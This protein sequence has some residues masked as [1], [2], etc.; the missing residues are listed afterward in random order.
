M[1]LYLTDSADLTSVADAIR[2]KGGTAAPLAFPQGFV[3]AID[4]IPTGGGASVKEELLGYTPQGDVTYIP[5]ENIPIHGICGKRGMTSLTLDFAAG[6]GFASSNSSGYNL[7]ANHIPKITIRGSVWLPA[8]VFYDNSSAFVVVCRDG[9]T[10]Y[11]QNVFR[12]NSG[13]TTLDFTYTTGDGIGVNDFYGDSAFGT[14]IIR[15]SSVMPLSNISAFSNATKFRNGGSGGKLYVPQALV[16]EY[17]Q[18]TN[19]STILGYANNQILPIE[20]SIYETQYADGTPI[21]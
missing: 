11:R 8:Y 4:A 16:S 20:G 1:S 9:V 14:L 7:N 21:T 15:S 12:Q 17:T 10:K 18:A 2:T 3:S 19:W 5:D 13:L 6:H